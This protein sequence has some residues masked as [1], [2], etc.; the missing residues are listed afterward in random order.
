[1]GNFRDKGK[2]LLDKTSVKSLGDLTGPKS[3]V[4]AQLEDITLK[5]HGYKYIR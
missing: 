4:L 3:E 2:A 1:M 5:N